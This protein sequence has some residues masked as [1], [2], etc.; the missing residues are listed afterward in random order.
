MDCLSINSARIILAY[1]SLAMVANS[2]GLIWIMQEII[3]LA[4]IKVAFNHSAEI[5]LSFQLTR[6]MADLSRDREM[7][8]F[9]AS[10]VSQPQLTPA[11]WI[12]SQ[13]TSADPSRVD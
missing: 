12:R 7:P 11:E 13:P 3:Q 9:G 1:N 8:F 5:G 10:E 2:L 6:L 4:G